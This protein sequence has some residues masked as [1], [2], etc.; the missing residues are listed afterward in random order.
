MGEGVISIRLTEE[1]K[2]VLRD[3]LSAVETEEKRH[4]ALLLTEK[5]KMPLSCWKIARYKSQAKRLH[6]YTYCHLSIMI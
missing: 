2:T 4:Q 3:F 5:V 6:R 1:N